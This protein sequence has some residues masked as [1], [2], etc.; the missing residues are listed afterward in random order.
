MEANV[1]SSAS[2]VTVPDSI[3]ERSRLSLMRFS[4]SVP[5]P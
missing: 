2:I 3:F 4:R 1:S 5:A